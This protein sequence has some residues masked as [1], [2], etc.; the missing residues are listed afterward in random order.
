MPDIPDNTASSP[1]G[2]RLAD[3]GERTFQRPPRAELGHAPR[4]RHL[5]NRG[6]ARTLIVPMDH[7]ISMGPVPGLFDM[8]QTVQQ[9]SGTGVNGVV[10]HKGLVRSI[11]PVLRTAP[12]VGLIIHLCGST[13][14]APDPN[15]K[16]LVCTVQ[17]AL[18]QGADGVSVHVNIGAATEGS[19]LRDFAEVAEQ[20]HNLK[21][22]LL[23]MVY[24]RGPRQR[25]KFS[26]SFNAHCARVA[27]E[28]GAD[29]VKVQYTGTREGFAQVVSAVPIPVLIA[30]GPKMN[31]D[32][33]VLQMVWESLDAGAAGISIGRNVFGADN[34][35]QLCRAL[36]GL[37]HDNL[38]V[39]DAVEI[40]N[41]KVS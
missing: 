26:E 37:I 24:A 28:I 19:M 17:E 1:S 38:S 7:G 15:E 2:P 22:P 33:E 39:D 23:A 27:Y 6:N 34:V 41:T 31:D 30:G 29:Y 21:V 3:T 18:A 9:M 13:S 4:L 40:L 5:F 25:V 14:E 16:Q 10:V 12:D 36:A 11:A 20:C 35:P 32:R 8:R